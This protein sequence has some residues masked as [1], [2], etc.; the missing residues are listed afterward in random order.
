[1]ADVDNTEDQ[2]IESEEQSQSPGA[3]STEQVEQEEQEDQEAPEAAEDSQ[4]EEAQEE[5]PPKPSRRENL[6]IQQLV[7]KLRQQQGAVSAPPASRSDGI[8]YR[9]ALDADDEVITQLEAD[10]QSYGQ[11]LYQQ[12]MK[13]AES[14]QFHTRLEIDAPKVESKYSFL[15]KGDVEHFNPVAANAINE[16]Y[17]AT[18]GYDPQTNT[19]ANSNVRYADFVEGIME[20]A[21]ELAGNK[22]AVTTKNIVKQVANTGLRPDGSSAKR[23]NLNKAPESMTDEELNAVISQAIPRKN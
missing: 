13:Q 5:E 17:L 2:V 19:V 12:G 21:D 10:R 8:D 3:Q 15:D 11:T 23:L 20:L 7:S 22:V 18:A 4:A 14:L 1:M 6:R 9:T 16:W